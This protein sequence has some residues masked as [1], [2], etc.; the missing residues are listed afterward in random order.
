MPEGSG[1]IAVSPVA[2][3]PWVLFDLKLAMVP[4]EIDKLGVIFVKVREKFSGGLPA[5]RAW[6]SGMAELKVTL[7]GG[8]EPASPPALPSPLK[9]AFVNTVVRM[10]VP[11]GET[12]LTVPL[13]F[14]VIWPLAF[15]LAAPVLC[16]PSKVSKPGSGGP[17]MGVFAMFV[18]LTR[19]G[20]STPVALTVV[21]VVVAPAA[22]AWTNKFVPAG[23]EYERIGTALLEVAIASEASD[24]RARVLTETAF[25][26]LSSIVAESEG[27]GTSLSGADPI[28][29][30][31]KLSTRIPENFPDS[32]PA[33]RDSLS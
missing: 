5:I 31:C 9:A 27:C 17:T 10:F 26:G 32:T 1:T 25:M 8:L 21:N 20:V 12:I 16:T 23:W 6:I 14:C 33:E 30:V 15:T 4:P 2:A 19:S 28:V 3:P 7:S 22:V 13:K 29:A 24:A 18:M 11:V